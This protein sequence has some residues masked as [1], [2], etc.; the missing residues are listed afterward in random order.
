MPYSAGV[1]LDFLAVMGSVRFGGCLFFVLFVCFL[2]LCFLETESRSVAQAGMQWRNLGSLQ[3][4]LPSFQR[5]SCLSLLSSWD[6]GCPRP[7]PATFCIF[8]RDRVS[9]Y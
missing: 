8:S 1:D 2:F 9:A 4:P 3:P 7:C 5:F 6:Y